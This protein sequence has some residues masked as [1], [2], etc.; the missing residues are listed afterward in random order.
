MGRRRAKRNG[1]VGITSTVIYTSITSLPTTHL[2]MPTREMNINVCNKGV[3]AKYATAGELGIYNSY[4][5][6]DTKIHVCG[7]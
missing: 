7:N 5:G 4:Y 6:R 1:A 2:K 3:S